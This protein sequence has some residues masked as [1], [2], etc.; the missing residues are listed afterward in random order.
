LTNSE[1]KQLQILQSDECWSAIEKF[2]EE[3]IKGINLSGSM[4]RENEFETIWQRAY[5]EGGVENLRNFFK[6]LDNEARLYK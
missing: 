1:R 2:L 4:K 3:Y 5:N 6:A